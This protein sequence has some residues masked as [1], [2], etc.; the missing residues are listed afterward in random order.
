MS[1]QLQITSSLLS[2][3]GTYSWYYA[4]EIDDF[5]SQ[6]EQREVFLSEL[7]HLLRSPTRIEMRQGF[8]LRTLQCFL[9]TP[10]PRRSEPGQ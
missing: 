6:E 1:R 5:S 3:P 10:N 4:F 2:D 7:A 9:E 8:L